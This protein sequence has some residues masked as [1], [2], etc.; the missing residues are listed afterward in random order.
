VKNP[1]RDMKHHRYQ[2]QREGFWFS[3]QEPWLPMPVESHEKWPGQHIFLEKLANLEATLTPMHYKGPSR[4]RI[5]GC[6][7]GSSEYELSVWRW[8]QGLGHYIEKHN[9]RPSLAFQEFVMGGPLPRR[10]D[11]ER[12]VHHDKIDAAIFDEHDAWLHSVYSE[13]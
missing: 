13:T 5:C 7:N 3:Q 1:F 4:C 8:P 2:L 10:S 11:V 12:R 6:S 9:V